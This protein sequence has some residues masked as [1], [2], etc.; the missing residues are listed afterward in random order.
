M[1]SGTLRTYFYSA[2]VLAVVCFTYTVAFAQAPENVTA[3]DDTTG[4]SALTQSLEERRRA[5]EETR[6]SIGE[7]RD[8]VVSNS[9]STTD[10]FKKRITER[11]AQLAG[12]VK[13]RIHNLFENVAMR[14]VAITERFDQISARLESRIQKS[15]A[16]G[17]NTAEA[18]RALAEAKI[19]LS[20]AKEGI[21]A[22]S[23]TK[24]DHIVDADSP[25]EK[26]RTLRISIIAIRE[27]LHETQR[28]L[29][30]TVTAL[31]NQTSTVPVEESSS[32]TINSST[33]STT[34]P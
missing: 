16:A 18:E 27:S 33:S 12:R 14:L 7:R 13:E 3:L 17:M 8:E 22:I 32:A 23:S 19:K 30:V 10:E 34:T 28:L 2:T 31:K 11:R 6:E 15:K 1:Q 24:L 21:R 9:A 4:D 5:Y 20:E 29:L 26:F 25:V